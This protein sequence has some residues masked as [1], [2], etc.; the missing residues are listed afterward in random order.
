M[1]VLVLVLVLALIGGP[2]LGQTLTCQNTGNMRH[3]WK[4][5]GETVI[6]EERGPGGYVHS[7]TPDGKAFTTWDHNGL[8]HTWPTSHDPVKTGPWMWPGVR[9]GGAVRTGWAW[10]RCV[11]ASASDYGPLALPLGRPFRVRVGVG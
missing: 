7:W 3:C 6:T 8:S 2:A 5:R 10:M 9:P 1:K 4:E 11:L